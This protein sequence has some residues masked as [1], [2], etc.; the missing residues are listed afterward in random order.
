MDGSSSGAAGKPPDRPPVPPAAATA[1]SRARTPAGPITAGSGGAGSGPAPLASRP[2]SGTD[3]ASPVRST[4]EGPVA[5]IDI[6]DGK[7]N[8]LG[9]DVLAGIQAALDR[10]EQDAEAVVLAGRPG[11][12]SAGFDLSVMT[13]GPEGARDLLG[14]GAELGLRLFEFPQPVVLAVTG[15]ALAMGGILLCCADI[16]VGADGPFKI[17]LNEVAIGM[18]VPGFAVELCRDRL[19]KRS[20]TQ[21]IQLARIHDPAEALE[22][23]FLDQVIPADDVRTRAIEVATELAGRL[24]RGPFRATRRT[25]RSEVAAEL[26]T[27]LAADLAAFDVTT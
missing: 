23:G 17:G 21:A 8:A 11:K 5:V 4:I 15:H 10:A 2:M 20:F 7:A 24:H 16:R 18:P 1:Q 13:S 26:R 3:P 12:F 6:D 25:I 22:A 14:Q 19:S 9:F 27:Q